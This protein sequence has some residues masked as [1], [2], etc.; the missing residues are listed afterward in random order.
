MRRIEDRRFV[1]GKGD[2]VD[3]LA[4]S[5]VTFAYVVRSPHAHAKIVGIDK[6]AAR[7]APGVLCVLTGQD[8]IAENIKGLPCPGFPPAPAGAR[9]YRPVRPVLAADIVRHVGDGVALV[10]AQTLH[11]AKDA[12]E[13]LAVD[14]EL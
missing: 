6:S 1:T 2:F 8:A 10:V 4:P 14:Y 3:D 12:A 5:G 9:F 11:Q 13:L 7:T